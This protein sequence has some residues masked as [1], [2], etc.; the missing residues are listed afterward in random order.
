MLKF[1]IAVLLILIASFAFSFLAAGQQ[2]KYY[3][4]PT[5]RKNTEIYPFYELWGYI[6]APIAGLLVVSTVVY[7]ARKKGN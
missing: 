6:A 2:E 5:E 4:E 3:K 7:R 1:C